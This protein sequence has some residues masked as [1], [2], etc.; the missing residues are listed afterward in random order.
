M[1]IVSEAM[2]KGFSTRNMEFVELIKQDIQKRAQLEVK[3]EEKRKIDEYYK[4]Q[5]LRQAKEVEE[6]YKNID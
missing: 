2:S 4:E 3:K 6:M 1:Q 5:L